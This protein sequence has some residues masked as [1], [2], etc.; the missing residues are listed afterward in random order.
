VKQF[1]QFVQSE[2]GTL[3]PS[4]SSSMFFR[5]EAGR[6]LEGGKINGLS[7]TEIAGVEEYEWMG[8]LLPLSPALEANG[9]KHDSRMLLSHRKFNPGPEFAITVAPSPQLDG[10]NTV[11]GEVLQGQELVLAMAQLPFVTGKSLDP[12]GSPS[13]QWWQAQNRY[14]Q[15]L[16]KQLGD[17]RVSNKYPGKL[18]RRV[19][20]TKCGVL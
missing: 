5:Q 10:P 13:D 7:K 9:L 19:E 11:F 12:S 4:Y 1:L 8:R 20:V 18:L 3:G 2:Q 15:S 14:F 16:A 17:T 6:W